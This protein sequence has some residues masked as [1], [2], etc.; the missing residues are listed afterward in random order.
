MTPQESPG[1]LTSFA[2]MRAS[3]EQLFDGYERELARH[4]EAQQQADGLTGVATSGDELVTVNV[5][6]TG[7]ITGL[8]LGWETFGR[9]TP[10]QLAE[11][12]VATARAATDEVRAD[13]SKLAAVLPV[14][15]S[16]HTEVTTDAK[17]IAVP[18]EIQSRVAN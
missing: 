18:T 8:D 2:A 12:I 17:P 4:A 16:L 15:G 6:H 1:Q 14:N 10:A 7:A 11:T 9:Y 5:D 3:M 13:A